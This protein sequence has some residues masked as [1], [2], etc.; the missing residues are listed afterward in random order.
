L[1][2]KYYIVNIIYFKYVEHHTIKPHDYRGHYCMYLFLIWERLL[3]VTGDVFGR[4]L[5]SN[6]SGADDMFIKNMHCGLTLVLLYQTFLWPNLVILPDFLRT[7][8]RDTYAKMEIRAV[9][10]LQI[11]I[12]HST[13]YSLELQKGYSIV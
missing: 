13:L 3:S 12:L 10:W 7:T 4:R 11:R 5:L 8:I 2:V 9:E 6:E 1:R